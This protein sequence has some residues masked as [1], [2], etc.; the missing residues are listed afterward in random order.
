MNWKT[1]GGPPQPAT[2]AAPPELPEPPEAPSRRR[3]RTAVVLLIILVLAALAA[4]ALI[5]MDVFES[6]PVEPEGPRE[7]SAALIAAE[8]PD[9]PEAA[10]LAWWR[11]VQYRN[12]G[13]AVDYYDPALEIVPEDLNRQL[14]LAANSFVGV[15]TIESVD[16]VEGIDDEPDRATIYISHSRPG[17]DAPPRQIALNLVFV[18]DEW[19][20]EDNLMIQQIVNRVI[21]SRIE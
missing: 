17:S 7:V 9:S 18:D 10:I 21:Q 11:E 1:V 13:R 12:A 15:P 4:I 6:D 2:E 20:L 8:D 16:V 3:W 14:L 5:Q 19:K